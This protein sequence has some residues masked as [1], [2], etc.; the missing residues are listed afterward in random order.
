MG[1]EVW[2]H[3]GDCQQWHCALFTGSCMA[4][5]VLVQQ[6][7]TR[8]GWSLHGRPQKGFHITAEAFYFLC[9]FHRVDVGST[10]PVG[11]CALLLLTNGT[12]STGC[13]SFS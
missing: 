6:T 12:F 1:A 2:L 11:G 5:Q 3:S 9:A 7:G 10:E 4:C 13:P 8:T